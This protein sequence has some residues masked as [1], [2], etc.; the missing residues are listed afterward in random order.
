MKM[1]LAGIAFKNVLKNRRRTILNMLTFSVSVFI[2]LLGFGMVKG[3]FNAIYERMIDL[4]TGHLKIYNKAYPEVKSTLPLDQAIDNPEA[5]VEAIKNTPY[6]VAASPRLVHDGLIS[7]KQ[8]KVAVLIHGIM[9][10]KEKKILT[11]Y[12]DIEGK[13]IPKDGAF[14]L[15]GKALSALLGLKPGTGMLL[16][17]QT[18]GNMNN[19]VDANV[20]GVYS[21]GFDA[22]EKMNVYIPF[23]FAQKLLDMD[24]KATEIIIRLEKSADVPAAKKYIREILAKQFPNLVVADWKE[25]LADLFE[26]AKAK[27]GSFNTFVF[28]FLFLSFF[29]VVNTMTMSVFERTAEIG[30][31]RAIGFNR[32][33]IRDLFMI[34]GFFLALFG[35][36][37]GWLLSAWPTYYLNEHGLIL[38]VMKQAGT[39]SLPMTSVLKSYNTVSDWV[40]TAVICILAGVLG[41]YFPAQM[42]AN[43]N[44]VSALK[45]GVR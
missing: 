45:R 2:I 5:V 23:P 12:N 20:S 11:A 22:M 36:A 32:G 29:I 15:V 9:L 17:S 16:F 27:M 14:V 44:I 3:Q 35:V 7:N 39:N 28:I 31:L 4:R 1:E 6:L 8:K 41:A 38:D 21:I 30:T 33:D 10:E 19:L 25:E 13:P 42:A 37:L 24:N 40:T 34:E 18:S 43:T 26:L